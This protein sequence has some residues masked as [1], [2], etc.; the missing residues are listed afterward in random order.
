MAK[1]PFNPEVLFPYASAEIRPPIGVDALA[2][3]YAILV[4][5]EERSFDRPEPVF[6]A[7]A[8]D[9]ENLRA[10]LIDGFGGL[11]VLQPQLG[12]GLRDP[13]DPTSLELNKNVP[14]VVYAKPVG[15][16]DRYIERLQMELQEA[17]DQGLV[18]VERQEV[19][20]VGRYRLQK[21]KQIGAIP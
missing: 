4:P 18:L 2:W 10:L 15:A 11:T 13:E 6:L 9:L 20:L 21:R 12:S 14:F 16:S 8:T 17:F 5:L 1:R 7:D 19:F 3:R